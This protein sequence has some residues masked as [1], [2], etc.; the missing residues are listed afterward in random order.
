MKQLTG[1]QKKIIRPIVLVIIC[2]LCFAIINLYLG[3][4]SSSVDNTHT[5]SQNSDTQDIH[6]FKVFKSRKG[7]YG[8]VD[9]N[10]N[11]IIKPQWSYIDAVSENCFIVACGINGVQTYGMLDN[12]ENVIAGLAYSSLEY[13]GKSLII[14]R[15]ADNGK[16][17]ILKPD[18][19]VYIDDAWDSYSISGNDITLMKNRNRYFARIGDEKPEFY[20]FEIKKASEKISFDYT[21][22]FSE[23]DGAVSH[24]IIEQMTEKSAQYL[25]AVENNDKNY[26][27]SITVPDYYSSVIP[28]EYMGRKISDISEA[29]VS[30]RNSD[31]NV[32]YEID[33]R[34]KFSGD[35]AVSSETYDTGQIQNNDMDF[36]IIMDKDS[37]GSMIITAVYYTDMQKGL[38]DE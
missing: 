14:G 10:D 18:G 4:Q 1:N 36:I 24:K 25:R 2:V 5:D 32:I 21:F 34:L 16:Y 11:E 23:Y 22:D 9:M 6:D 12:E 31:G 28:S 38:Y 37:S 15:T 20:S 17:M 19:S 27:M 30:I 3:S 7:L 26:I 35:E 29:S 8:V 33:F 13:I